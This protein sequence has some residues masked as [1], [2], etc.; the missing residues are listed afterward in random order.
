MSGKS[1][2]FPCPEWFMRIWNLGAL[3]LGSD[4]DLVLILAT[5]LTVIRGE[6]GSALLWWE[7]DLSKEAGGEKGKAVGELQQL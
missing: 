1:Y 4:L 2:P 5:D 7:Q 3:T 6:R